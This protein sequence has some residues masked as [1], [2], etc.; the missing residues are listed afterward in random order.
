MGLGGSSPFGHNHEDVNKMDNVDILA[1]A[2][3]MNSITILIVIIANR[4]KK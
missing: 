1:I 2:V 3:L 4:D